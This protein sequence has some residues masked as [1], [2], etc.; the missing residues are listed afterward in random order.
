MFGSEFVALETRVVQA[1]VQCRFYNLGD[2]NS[3]SRV[4]MS[5][6]KLSFFSGAGTTAAGTTIWFEHGGQL[7]GG[8]AP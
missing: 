7:Q 4:G 8:R 5:S 3:S 6:Q 2:D 1:C